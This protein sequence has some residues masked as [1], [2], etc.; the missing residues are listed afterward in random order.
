[1]EHDETG[2]Q[3]PDMDEPESKRV[4]RGKLLKVA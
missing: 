2:V 4:S 3:N 1:M